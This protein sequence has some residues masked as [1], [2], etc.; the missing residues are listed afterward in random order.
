MVSDEKIL[1]TLGEMQGAFGALVTHLAARMIKAG[2]AE[3]EDLIDDVERMAAA[4]GDPLRIFAQIAD[5]LKKMRP[6]GVIEGGKNE[7]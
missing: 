1:E 5:E 3:R 6:W 2:V 7:T 4:A